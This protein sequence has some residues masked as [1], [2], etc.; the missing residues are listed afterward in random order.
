MSG[1]APKTVE[2][3]P[4]IEGSLKDELV[5]Q[6]ELKKTEASNYKKSYHDFYS[7]TIALFMWVVTLENS[8]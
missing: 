4:K 5:K 6:H 8:L 1:D 2:E 7:K 3:L